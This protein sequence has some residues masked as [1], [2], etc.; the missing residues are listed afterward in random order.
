[1]Q[2]AAN[3]LDRFYPSDESVS[4]DHDIQAFKEALLS[5]QGSNLRK[6][7]SG[8]KI[9]TRKELFELAGYMIFLSVAH[10]ESA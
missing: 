5:T 3:A 6:I 1:M 4:H 10:G 8:N 2:F 9:N 7:N